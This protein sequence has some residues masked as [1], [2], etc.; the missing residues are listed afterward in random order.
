MQEIVTASPPFEGLLAASLGLNNLIL[1]WSFVSALVGR[2]NTNL[3]RGLI[4]R[5]KYVNGTL[6]Y[7]PVVG[8][9][10]SGSAYPYGRSW[11]VDTGGPLPSGAGKPD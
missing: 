8:A 1:V 7:E 4:R 2:P 11:A 3:I 9:T 5:Q 6:A 10:V